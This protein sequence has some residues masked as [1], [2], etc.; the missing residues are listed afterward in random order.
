LIACCLSRPLHSKERTID[1]KRFCLIIEGVCPNSWNYLQGSCYN[2]FSKATSWTAAKSACEALGAKLVVLNSFTENRAV[3]EKITGGRGTYIGL[4]RNP[5]DKSRWLW[6]DQSRSTY[7]HWD[8]GEPNN[9]GGSEDCVHMRPKS[10]RYEWND[11]PCNNVY[12]V[13]Y[14]CE[15]TGKS[16]SVMLDIA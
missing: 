7:T 11:L 15:T 8:S 9:A 14:V 6:V 3:G 10:Y 12:N 4:Y 1:F 13:P 5:R 2:F 16:G